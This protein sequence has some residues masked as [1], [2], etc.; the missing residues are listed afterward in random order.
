MYRFKI[1]IGDPYDD[2]HGKYEDFIINSN[3]SKK[4]IEIAYKKVCELTGLVFTENTDI[5][6]NGERIDWQHP[7]YND[8]KICVEYESY[9]PSKLAWDILRKYGIIESKAGYDHQGFLYL[10]MDF[11]KIELT[12]LEYKIESENIES[13]NLN[14]G[15]G[16]FH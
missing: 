11:I 9:E 3:K 4:E 7:E 13:L 16:R 6:V 1:E 14:I 12:D 2:G 8:R 15:Y 10:F 5:I